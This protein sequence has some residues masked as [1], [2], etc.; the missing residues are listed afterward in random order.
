MK[1]KYQTEIEGL[2]DEEQRKMALLKKD[3]NEIS[4]V[5]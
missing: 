2:R 4:E 5:K 3:L 1:V